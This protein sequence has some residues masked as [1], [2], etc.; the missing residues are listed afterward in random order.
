MQ[1]SKNPK[2]YTSEDIAVIDENSEYLGVPRLLLMENAGKAVAEEVKKLLGDLEGRKIVVVCGVGNNGG[3]GMVAARHLAWHR[4]K[5]KVFLM[6]DPSDIRTSEARANWLVLER[7]VLTVEKFTV[8]TSRDLDVLRR[9]VEDADV[10]IDAILG[11][12][13]KGVLREP[14]LTAVK[15]INHSKALKIA[16]DVPTGLNP[17]T[18]LVHGDAVRANLTVTLHGVKPGLITGREYSGSIVVACIG[19]PPEAE[20][21][22]GPGDVKAVLKPRPPRSHKGD[23]GRL[24][25]IGGSE[26][27]TGAPSLAALAAFRTGVDLAIVATPREVVNTI[28]SYSPNI[29]A[30]PLKSEKHLSPCDLEVLGEEVRKANCVILGP[31]LGLHEETVEAV[32]ELVKLLVKLGKPFLIDADGI[33]A[34][35]RDTGVLKGGLGVLTPHGRE[36]AMLTG[37][38]PP[39]NLQEKIESVKKAALRLKVVIL[40]KGHVDVISDG[41]KTKINLTGNPGMT[42]GGTGDVLSGIVGCLMA[43]GVTPFK[44]AVAGAFISGRAGDLALAEKGYQLVPTDV[45]EKIPEVLKELGVGGFKEKTF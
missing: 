10:V 39:L 21:V 26:F 5:V 16:V 32:L 35:S 18:G 1:P 20:L 27:F 23:Y 36:Y 43:F 25:I 15:I 33:K 22:A 38:K 7:M 3:D 34:V 29:I 31:G 28:R 11:T 6:G 45:I 17:N 13:V 12:G 40:L 37:E 14:L 30:I 41:E 24:L 2:T 42:V 19:A 44:A 4:A 8:K 9:E